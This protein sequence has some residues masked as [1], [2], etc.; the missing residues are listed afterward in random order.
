M[1]RGGSSSESNGAGLNML[2][3]GDEVPVAH[4][5]GPDASSRAMIELVVCC[6]VRVT[7]HDACAH[8]ASPRQP[9]VGS[10]PP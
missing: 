10:V 5:V 4:T 8:G 7:S 6:A 1:G 3:H 2:R 9:L